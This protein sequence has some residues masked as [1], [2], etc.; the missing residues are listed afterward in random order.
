ME[1]Y[2]GVAREQGISD[3]EIAMT[4]A[5]VMSISACRVR[6]QFREAEGKKG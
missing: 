6:T 1:H 5:I 4:K 2:L 3:E